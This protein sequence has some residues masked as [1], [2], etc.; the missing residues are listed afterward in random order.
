[1]SFY[2]LYG[3]LTILIISHLTV[4]CQVVKYSDISYNST[5]YYY[6]IYGRGVSRGKEGKR[7]GKEGRTKGRITPINAG[8]QGKN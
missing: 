2:L 7:R 8:G 4:L 5:Y 1:V 3:L 6:I